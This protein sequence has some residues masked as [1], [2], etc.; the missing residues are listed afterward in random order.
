MATS[1]SLSLSCLAKEEQRPPTARVHALVC[2]FCVTLPCWYNAL[3]LHYLLTTYGTAGLALSLSLSLSLACLLARRLE[4]GIAR[5]PP[6]SA[7]QRYAK[8]CVRFVGMRMF[9]RA[10]ICND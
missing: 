9:A 2:L 5:T 10:Q 6:P 1:L 4:V 8:V 3:A 7:S